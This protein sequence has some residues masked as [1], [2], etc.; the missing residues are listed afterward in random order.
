MSHYTCFVAEGFPK[1][2][3][4]SH[5]WTCSI[6]NIEIEDA[7]VTIPPGSTGTCNKLGSG[8]GN[9]SKFGYYNETLSASFSKPPG[10]EVYSDQY[11]E[12]PICNEWFRQCA[13]ER[14]ASTCGGY[15]D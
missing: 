14:H 1:N 10:S 2:K 7:V 9:S 12:C 4:V 15:I 13:V 11:V 8:S 5:K 6:D 3:L